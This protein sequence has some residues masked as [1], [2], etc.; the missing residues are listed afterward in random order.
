MPFA[1]RSCIIA[2]TLLTTTQVLSVEPTPANVIRVTRQATNSPGNGQKG[3]VQV[4][5]EIRTN[6]EGVDFAD[7]KR[8]AY[9]S[10]KRKWFARMPSSVTKGEKG[11]VEIQF[12]VQRDGKVPYDSL[13]LVSSS[14]KKEFDDASLSAIREAAPFDHLPSNFS[15]PFIELYLIFKYNLE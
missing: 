10:I 15:K 13:K 2:L 11:V 9:Q 3:I 4:T 14:G 5:V 7:F 12:Q 6:T 1:T 8:S